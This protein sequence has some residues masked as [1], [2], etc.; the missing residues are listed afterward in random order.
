MLHLQFARLASGD[1]TIVVSKDQ[2]ACTQHVQPSVP[3][4]LNGRTVQLIDTPGFRSN[5]V[6][7]TLGIFAELMRKS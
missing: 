1:L 7:D 3:F 2:T 6:F 5:N 4:K